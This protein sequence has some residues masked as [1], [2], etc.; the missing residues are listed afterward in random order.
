MGARKHD[1]R[2]QGDDG[3]HDDGGGPDDGGRRRGGTPHACVRARS[4][5]C[6]SQWQWGAVVHRRSQSVPSP[7]PLRAPSERPAPAAPPIPP[8]DADPTGRQPARSTQPPNCDSPPTLHTGPVPIA[9]LVSVGGPNWASNAV[10]PP[11]WDHHRW[12]GR[13]YRTARKVLG[14]SRPL[15]GGGRSLISPAIHKA[16]HVSPPAP[17]RLHTSRPSPLL[18]PPPLPSRVDLCHPQSHGWSKQPQ[19]SP[20]PQN[21]GLGPHMEWASVAR[22]TLPPPP[23]PF[24]ERCWIRS[25]QQRS[26][27]SAARFSCRS[28]TPGGPIWLFSFPCFQRCPAARFPVFIYGRPIVPAIVLCHVAGD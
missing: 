28:G 14:G 22:H 5:E 27:R 18:S 8:N 21:T 7:P 23:A 25:G 15:I 11:P 9:G 13:R 24:R 10:F 20:M 17:E 6:A 3:G 12:R 2:G 4:A 19:R 26:C 16:A 1:G